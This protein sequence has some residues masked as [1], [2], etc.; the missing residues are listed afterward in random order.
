MYLSAGLDGHHMM[1]KIIIHAFRCVLGLIQVTRPNIFQQQRSVSCS[2]DE[3]IRRAL[4]LI[5][6]EPT[7]KD[8]QRKCIADVFTST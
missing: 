6:N 5:S 8:R 7:V 4:R 3:T 2:M 1:I